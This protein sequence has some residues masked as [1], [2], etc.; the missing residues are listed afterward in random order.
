MKFKS[1]KSERNRF[2]GDEFMRNEW[3]DKI[4]ITKEQW[5]EIFLNENIMK[6]FNKD[7]ILR[8]YKKP[9]FMATATEI[10]NDEGRKPSSY[11]S[12]VGALGKR[13]VQ[14]LKIQPPRQ[15]EDST[16]LNYWHVMFL[17]S[18]E[19]DTGHFIWILRP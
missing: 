5:K 2:I 7:L 15:K 17:A 9:N 18:R 3:N 14:H 1:C 8:I 6:N 4:D 19:K 12:A 11:N 13:I 10:A 16:K